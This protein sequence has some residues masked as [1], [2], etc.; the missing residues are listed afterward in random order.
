MREGLSYET[1]SEEFRLM[2]KH[3]Y[4][5]P[6]AIVA[7][8]SGSAEAQESDSVYLIR[9]YLEQTIQRAGSASFVL[10]SIGPSPFHA[11][12]SVRERD[13]EQVGDAATSM[14]HKVQP[15]YHSIVWNVDT[16]RM[17]FEAAVA[18][19]LDGVRHDAD[20]FYEITQKRHVLLESW[21]EASKLAHEV[22]ILE[23]GTSLGSRVWNYPK[24]GRCMK[25]AIMSVAEHQ[26]LDIETRADIISILGEHVW[27]E[28][29]GI[30]IFCEQKFQ[31]LE[32]FPAMELR[33]LLQF[34]EN[35]ARHVDNV[36]IA[37][38]AAILGGLVGGTL[39]VLAS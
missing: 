5:S 25:D 20:V 6:V 18:K 11:D 32:K 29:M 8:M 13:E 3:C 26:M 9:N 12:F 31:G 33:E 2:I 35:R 1:D 14:V 37:L 27:A 16:R 21:A 19:V 30:R 17:P 23:R 28:D 36:I 7:P 15:G 34:L 4:Y 39:G 24:K 10:D 22:T 38:L